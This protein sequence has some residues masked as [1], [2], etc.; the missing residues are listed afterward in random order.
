[1]ANVRDQGLQSAHDKLSK[2]HSAPTMIDP[3]AVL[4]LEVI[5]MVVSYLSYPTLVYDILTFI[6]PQ[7]LLMRR[8]DSSPSLKAMEDG[9]RISSACVAKSRSINDP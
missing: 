8:Q 2:K 1:M 5:E 4:P 9:P 6:P 7:Y 3:F